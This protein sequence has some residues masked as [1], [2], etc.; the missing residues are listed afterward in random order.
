M[1]EL[2]V[3]EP[4]VWRC[5]AL[6]ADES[7]IEFLGL[8]V[9]SLIPFEVRFESVKLRDVLLIDSMPSMLSLWK[10]SGCRPS[11]PIVREEPFVFRLLL[12]TFCD[13][14]QSTQYVWQDLTPDAIP[15]NVP[16]PLSFRDSSTLCGNS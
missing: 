11:T 7:R 2:A 14:L 15:L 9:S 12:R 16:P 3:L 1:G 4:L 10:S 13:I 5:D 8:F 6:E